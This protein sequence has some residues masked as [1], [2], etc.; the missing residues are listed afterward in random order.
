M[1]LIIPNP[2]DKVTVRDRQ[3]LEIMMGEDAPTK[4]GVVY[5]VLDPDGHSLELPNGL[6]VQVTWD[7]LNSGLKI[8]KAGATMWAFDISEIKVAT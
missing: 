4:P 1:T 7:R 6:A 2:G 5:E 8:P 3:L